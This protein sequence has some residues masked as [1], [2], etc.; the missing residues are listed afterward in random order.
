MENI[1]EKKKRTLGATLTLIATVIT[2]IV[3]IITC[4][5]II[6][7]SP[8]EKLQGRGIPWTAE[9]FMDAIRL[10]NVGAVKLF[11][12]G[13]M[14]PYVPN[15][16]SPLPKSICFV[17]NNPDKL[18]ETIFDNFKDFDINKEYDQTPTF[19]ISTLMNRALEVENIAL[20]KSLIKHGVDPSKK[21]KVSYDGFSPY[22]TSFE[23]TP[24]NYIKGRIVKFGET[25]KRTEI[26]KYLK[27]VAPNSDREPPVKAMTKIEYERAMEDFQRDT[28]RKAAEMIQNRGVIMRK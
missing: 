13:G 26:A 11:L 16:K 24:L 12:Q 23:D 19:P 18:L 17:E 8:Q 20:I 27:E 2:I 7:K 9:N 10:N 22:G 25:N 6:T 28:S 5:Q 3:G 21:L 15:Q 4:Y 1:K 14:S